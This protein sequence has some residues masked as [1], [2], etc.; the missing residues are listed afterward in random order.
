MSGGADTDGKRWSSRLMFLIAAIGFAV[1]LGNLWRFPYLAGQNGGGAFV[2][3]YIVA[4]FIIGLPLVI[5]EVAVGRAGGAN[6][7]RAWRKVAEIQG[8][9][10]WWSVIGYLGIVASFLVVSFYCVIGGWTLAFACNAVSMLA[11]GG[12]PLDFGG[13]LADPLALTGWQA[14]FLLANLAIIRLGLEKGVERAMA[15]MMPLLLVTLLGLLAFALFQPG[16]ARAATFLFSFDPA[17]V[18]WDS[19]MKAVGHAFFS[20]GVGAAVLVTYGG[21]L[22]PEEKIGRLAAIIVVAQTIVAL[23]AGLIIFPFVF[24]AG[25]DPSEGPTLLFVTMQAAFAALPGGAW[26]AAVFFILVAM[27]ALTSSIALFEMLAAIGEARGIARGRLLGG[28]GAALWAIGLGTVFSFNLA[29]DWHPL[30]R[31]PLF[32]GA[33]FFGVLDIVT[34]A[35]A[36]P[37]GGLL[38]A[39]FAG[40]IVPRESWAALIGWPQQSKALGAWLLVLRVPVPLILI[41]TLARGLMG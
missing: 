28:A 37:L 19:V 30:Q 12:G 21:Y 15:V 23:L 2:L 1:G 3:L 10:P 31:V 39:I 32:A 11:S 9:S 40:W 25:L 16:F 26:L 20:V 27:A 8:A 13:L 5:A 36:M 33:N 38:A 17:L 24:T 29:A 14:A 6:P 7:A 41:V 4:V 34:S 22:G 35:I 18:T